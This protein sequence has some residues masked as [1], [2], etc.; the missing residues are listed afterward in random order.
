MVAIWAHADSV[1]LSHLVIRGAARGGVQ[2]DG[3]GSSIDA[4]EVA[5]CSG[6][7]L[8][9]FGG[10][11]LSEVFV[12]DCSGNGLDLESST[13]SVTGQV[14]A[15]GNG[16]YGFRG[17]LSNL[18]AIAPAAAD[19]DSLLGNGKD[20]LDI[21]TGIAHSP[22]TVRA[23]IPWRVENYI[24]VD[25]G[26][27]MTIQ[28]GAHL[29][30]SGG[31]T[32]YFGRGGSL[33]ARGTDAAPI[34][35]T[36]SNTGG[37]WGGLTFREPL[38]PDPISVVVDTSYL[39]NAR[40]ERVSNGAGTQCCAINGEGVH[41]V[42]FLDSLVV[43]QTLVGGVVELNAAH[44]R[45]TYSVV[46][47]SGSPTGP[48]AIRVDGDSALLSH[49]VVRRSGGGGIWAF[50]KGMVLDSI[51]I[52][53]CQGDGVLLG[54]PYMTGSG[55]LVHGCTGDGVVSSVNGTLSA[56][57]IRAIGNG[58]YGF[59][60]LIN[61]LIAIAP[62]PAGQDSLLGNSKDTLYVTGG[63]AHAPVT[64]RADVPWRM[65]SPA[66]D[67]GSVMTVQPGSH[68]AFDGGGLT[69]AR[70]GRLDARGTAAAPIVFTPSITSVPWGGLFFGDPL[71]PD[72]INVAV[73]TSYLSNARLELV[74][75][76]NGGAIVGGGAHHTLL[77]DS[78]R[79]RR[80][81]VGAAV[82]LHGYGSRLSHSV[83]DTT[84]S[85][86][87]T[88][89]AL[90][91]A[92]ST[93]AYGV[94][95]R[96]SGG[97]GVEMSGNASFTSSTVNGSL[98]NGVS[99]FGANAVLSNDNFFAN[100]GVG[101][102]SHGSAVNAEGNWWGDPAGPNGPSGDGVSGFVDFANWLASAVVIP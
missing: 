48:T 67:S 81:A 53:N 43:R 75:S 88:A 72:P 3:S 39:S 20:T 6:D 59:R 50:G 26:A 18:L 66:I 96:R 71:E 17:S 34:V 87:S 13:I 21:V 44:S 102:F 89:P 82:A 79:I 93:A 8:L 24:Q 77:L 94:V 11:A 38:E 98:G 40:L 37:S 51:E 35:F 32:I 65:A 9:A 14:R 47:T 41:H 54:A 64:V 63:T 57:G 76:V 52:A 68:L 95:V 45:L 55:I 30:V 16:G 46:D 31:G 78:L 69:F 60:G 25:S 1:H 4:V 70:G 100:G 15:V 23:D 62:T 58:G 33:D 91:L 10:L 84:G 61:N 99:V 74:S 36:P 85:P 49:V 101:V 90:L 22:I 80:T 29:A 42:L 27:V 2:S 92:D 12:H 7:G 56:V 28:P 19:Q 5:E 86:T 83:I 73:D 97:D